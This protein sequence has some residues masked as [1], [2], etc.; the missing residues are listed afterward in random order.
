MVSAGVD[1]LYRLRRLGAGV[2]HALQAGENRSMRPHERAL[3]G[4]GQALIQENKLRDYALDPDH[5]KGRDKARVFASALGFTQ[6]NHAALEAAIRGALP[7]HAAERR[8]DSRYG[9]VYS[10]DLPITGPLGS[11]IVRTGWLVEFGDQIPRLTSAYV[12]KKR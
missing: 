11:A 2:G 6:E 1:P 12:V 3:P 5:P 9:S 7:M 10:V 8:P 4:H